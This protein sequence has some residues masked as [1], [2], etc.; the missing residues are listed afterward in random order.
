MK[1]SLFQNLLNNF[2]PKK[3]SLL[4]NSSENTIELKHDSDNDYGDNLNNNQDKNGLLDEKPLFNINTLQSIRISHSI[5]SSK[6]SESSNDIINYNKN[7]IKINNKYEENNE[8]DM[9]IINLENKNIK[10][11]INNNKNEENVN[12]N[13]NKTT[14]SSI[15]NNKEINNIYNQFKI[16]E[17]FKE[18]FEEK[19][20]SHKT[21][22]INKNILKNN[23]KENY[24]KIKNEEMKIKSQPIT[25]LN[26]PMKT[27]KMN[28]IVCSKNK[29]NRQNKLKLNDSLSIGQ[30][31]IEIKENKSN[32]LIL[33]TFNNDDKNILVSELDFDLSNCNPL[34]A[35]NNGEIKNKIK[36]TEKNNER[37]NKK[38]YIGNNNTQ[39]K[40]KEKTNFIKKKIYPTKKINLNN[41]NN[42]KKNLIQLKKR[43]DTEKS[44]NNLNINKIKNIHSS[45]S[46]KFQRRNIPKNLDNIKQVLN[47]SN[48]HS[49]YIMNTSSNNINKK[50]LYNNSTHTLTEK[51]SYKPKYSS[52]SIHNE[53]HIN[54]KKYYR[55]TPIQKININNYFYN[56]NKKIVINNKNNNKSNRVLTMTILNNEDNV[57]NKNSFKKNNSFIIKRTNNL[58]NINNRIKKKFDIPIKNYFKISS[59]NKI[60]FNKQ[61]LY[62]NNNKIKNKINCFKNSIIRSNSNRV[63]KDQNNNYY[64][65]LNNDRNNIFKNIYKNK[66]NNNNNRTVIN[67]AYNSFTNNIYSIPHKTNLLINK[68]HNKS[69]ISVLND[70]KFFNNKS[71]DNINLLTEYE[72]NIHNEFRKL[73]NN[74][75]KSRE[76]IIP[77]SKINDK[78]I[79]N[80]INNY[81]RNFSNN[82]LITNPFRLKKY[83]YTYSSI[84]NHSKNKLVL[85]K[86]K[87]SFS[88]RTNNSS[89]N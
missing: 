83:K 43:L 49:S 50:T 8:N 38:N 15:H 34:K 21:T 58:L 61:K 69:K 87:N 51:F 60:P 66:K 82:S 20:R 80:N 26:N 44:H 17:I 41:N 4:D 84:N 29:N 31:S 53:Q 55:M 62:S 1:G 71:R 36:K 65:L 46:T 79:I 28:Y 67:T 24:N 85:V 27:Y 7:I 13:G 63:K 18:R 10:N 14:F 74:C 30:D 40:S 76:K 68:S 6:N 32:N 72:L 88:Y 2:K 78:Y 81:S 16:E 86:N 25:Y 23:N 37:N 89:K 47:N 56:D 3:I 39:N 33:E 54:L 35:K 70:K 42:S 75:K 64:Y 22:N 48:N 19:T 57:S 52:K 12:R 73:N 45:A 9:N 59:K 5:E 11:N 77:K